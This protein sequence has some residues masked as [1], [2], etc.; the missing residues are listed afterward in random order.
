MAQLGSEVGGVAREME[1]TTNELQRQ[2]GELER[3][4]REHRKTLDM[5]FRLQQ[6]VEEVMRTAVPGYCRTV[7]AEGLHKLCVGY[8]TSS[9]VR[10]QARPLPESGSF[11]WSVAAQKPSL[12]CTGSLRS[13]CGRRFL[14]RRRGS[15]RSPSSP[16]ECTVG[17]LQPGLSSL[18]VL[19]G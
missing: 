1:D 6:A 5:T 18:K 9:G 3:S 2:M 7:S 10:R 13:L 8:S 14:S 17:G 12:S 11:P 4:V 19:L 15:I 16:S